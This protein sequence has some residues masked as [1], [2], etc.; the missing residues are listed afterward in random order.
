MPLPP[1][2]V[3]VSL[4]QLKSCCRVEIPALQQLFFA[5]SG[6]KGELLCFNLFGYGVNGLINIHLH[7]IHALNGK[8][9]IKREK[10][11]C[12]DYIQAGE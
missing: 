1:L 10:E 12:H 9:M 6:S 3:S 11:G 4:Y 2:S 7:N 8:E 5:F